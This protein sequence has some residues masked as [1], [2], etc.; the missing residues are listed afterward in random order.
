MFHLRY[1]LS[2]SHLALTRIQVNSEDVDENVI[3]QHCF[4]DSLPDYRFNFTLIQHHEFQCASFFSDSIIQKNS[5]VGSFTGLFVH[6][7]VPQA[8]D[9]H[10]LSHWECSKLESIQVKI[11][12]GK[13]SLRD[14]NVAE[15]RY[16]DIEADEGGFLHIDVRMLKKAHLLKD[17]GIPC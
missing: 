13:C 4:L 1:L 11:F 15:I 5:A 8:Y 17:V 2:F 12:Y 6:N 9:F 10:E 7:D 14:E 16:N 3:F